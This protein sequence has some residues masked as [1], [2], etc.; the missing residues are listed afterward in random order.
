MVENGSPPAPVPRGAALRVARKSDE[1]FVPTTL[2]TYTGRMRMDQPNIIGE[3]V[4]N[5]VFSED[6]DETDSL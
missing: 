4:Q 1:L 2:T 5:E 3:C 6:A